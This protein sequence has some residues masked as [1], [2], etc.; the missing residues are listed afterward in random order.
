MRVKKDFLKEGWDVIDKV[1]DGVITLLRIVQ[2]ICCLNLSIL[3]MKF[4]LE[5]FFSMRAK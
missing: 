3:R 4:R 1:L 2:I 5:A